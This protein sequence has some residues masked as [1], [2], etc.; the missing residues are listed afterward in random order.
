MKLGILVATDRHL[1]DV[2]GITDAAISK[3][4]EVIIFNMDAGSRLLSDRDLGALC[5]RP[6]VTMSFC[7]LNA[8]QRGVEKEA[9]PEAI[10]RGS[11]LDNARMVHDADRVIRL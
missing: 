10:A 3:G 4:H 1:D 7:D 11:Q 6:G 8:T 5:E 2:L 9:L